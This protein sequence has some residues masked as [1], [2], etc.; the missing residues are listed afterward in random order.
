MRVSNG[1]ADITTT[2]SRYLC[3]HRSEVV[4]YRKLQRLRPSALLCH[5]ERHRVRA[6]AEAADSK[7]GTIQLIERRDG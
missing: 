7:I 6:R 1:F 2:Q 3:T 5:H 4:A